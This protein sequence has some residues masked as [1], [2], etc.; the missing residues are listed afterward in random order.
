[1]PG[2]QNSNETLDFL[3]T[4]GTTDRGDEMPATAKA[5]VELA[6]FLIETASDNLE[7]KGHVATGDT[8]SSMKA[9]NLDLAGPNKSIEVQILSTYKFIDQGVKGT[10]GGN[11]K[12]QFKNNFVGK[13]M[14]SAILRW[15]K[16]RSLSGRIK[17]RAVSKNERKNKQINKAVNDAKSRSSLAYA[18]ATNIK[19]NGIDR[20]L[21]FT[22]AVKATQKESKK[23]F[24]AALKIDIINS[25]NGN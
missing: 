9:V 20:T 5:L 22:N 18:V 21:F 11:G 23:K 2:I 3:G 13:K 7:R 24:A 8:I 12:Y 16:K 15:L 6:G 1:M 17:Y 4:I 14:H 19:K 10:K 25:I